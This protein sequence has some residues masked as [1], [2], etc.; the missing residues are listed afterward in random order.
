MR[1]GEL[2]ATAAWLGALLLI[3][4]QEAGVERVWAG[5]VAMA[6][7]LLLRLAAIHYH[8]TLPSFPVKPN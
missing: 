6:A 1:A 3:G 7:I 8:L 4:L 5:G 2:Y